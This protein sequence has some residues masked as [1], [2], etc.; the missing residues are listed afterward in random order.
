[1]W[2]NALV[3]APATTIS[4]GTTSLFVLTLLWSMIIQSRIPTGPEL[5]GS[6]FIATSV[7]SSIV[8]AVKQEHSSAT[9]PLPAGRRQGSDVTVG[10]KD[11]LREL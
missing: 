11:V 8:R 2:L 1:V 3:R 10:D 7:A 4:V 6:A 5:L 9:A